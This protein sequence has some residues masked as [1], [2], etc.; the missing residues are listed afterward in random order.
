MKLQSAIKKIEKRLEGTDYQ[1]TIEP[2]GK[3]GICGE[4]VLLTQGRV[5]TMSIGHKWDCDK[6]P[7][8][9]K[10]YQRKATKAE[11]MKYG[12][13]GTIHNRRENDHSDSMTDYFAG[14]FP[15]NLSQCLDSL[16]TPPSKYSTGMMIKFKD[17]KRMNRWNLANK[18]GVITESHGKTYTVLLLEDQK[19]QNHM[20]ERDIEE[21]K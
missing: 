9:L 19:P 7:E 17:N 15:R 3:K 14:Y 2:S 21:V 5:I 11:F 4:I 20:A 12:Y 1:M 16:V 18:I 13:V 6:T 10:S 8:K